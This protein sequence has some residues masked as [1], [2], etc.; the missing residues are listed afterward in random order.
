MPA[1]RVTPCEATVSPIPQKPSIMVAT[2]VADSRSP[3]TPE[4]LS[5]SKNIRSPASD[6]RLTMMSASYSLRQRVNW[7][8]G[9]IEATMP[10]Y[11]PPFS[12]VARSIV[13]WWRTR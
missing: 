11:V 2:R 4:E 3:D 1:W 9:G 13:R 8:S 7:S 10:R 6:A 12:M 5:P